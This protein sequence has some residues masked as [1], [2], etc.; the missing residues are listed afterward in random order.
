MGQSRHIAVGR[1][2]H[3]VS[4]FQPAQPYAPALG[5][6]S[7]S[8]QRTSARVCD[9]ARSTADVALQAASLMAVKL[10][11]FQDCKRAPEVLRTLLKVAGAA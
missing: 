2:A 5:L 7:L 8:E 11:S 9:E 10:G 4:A 1:L 3:G 6:R